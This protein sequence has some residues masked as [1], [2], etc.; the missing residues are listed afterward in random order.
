MFYCGKMWN[1]L[2]G[3]N[4]CNT[5]T[6]FDQNFA[7]KIEYGMEDCEFDEENLG[8]RKLFLRYS[9]FHVP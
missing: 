8:R 4:V 6:E 1:R 9:I 5:M 2:G 3:A 7:I